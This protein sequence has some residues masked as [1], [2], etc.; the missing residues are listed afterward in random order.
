MAVISTCWLCAAEHGASESAC[1]DCG[2]TL[3]DPGHPGA[4]ADRSRRIGFLAREHLDDEARERLTP[5]LV[6]LSDVLLDDEGV[7]WLS[8]AEHRTHPGLLVITDVALCFV[9]EDEI[10]EPGAIDL[11]TIQEVTTW[12]GAG[13]QVRVTTAETIAVFSEVGGNVWLQQFSDVLTTATA[14]VDG[15]LRKATA[16]ESADRPPG[17]APHDR[18]V[19]NP[20]P[21]QVPLKATRSCPPE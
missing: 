13:G 6:G 5:T 3:L 19:I 14:S 20:S 4:E 17:A 1:R 12:P 18:M 8:D 9:P 2:D 15:A 16:Y 21:D 10:E 7:I 11:G